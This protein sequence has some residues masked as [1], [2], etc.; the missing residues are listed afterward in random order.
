MILRIAENERLK[1][2]RLCKDREEIVFSG[3]SLII[4]KFEDGYS[5]RLPY[6]FK[7]V[8]YSN[9]RIGREIIVFQDEIEISMILIDEIAYNHF[10]KLQINH[11]ILSIGN[12]SINEIKIDCADSHSEHMTVLDFKTKK[13][14]WRKGA[15]VYLNGSKMKHE[16]VW[17]SGDRIDV[18]GTAICFSNSFFMINKCG[19]YNDTLQ[20]YH[21]CLNESKLPEIVSFKRTYGDIWFPINELIINAPEPE[22]IIES[23]QQPMIYTIGPALMMSLASLSAGMINA[24]RGY[25]AGRELIDTLSYLIIPATMFLSTILWTPLSR[26]IVRRNIR[27]R[28]IKRKN[29]Y[30]NLMISYKEQVRVF[31]N[32]YHKNSTLFYPDVRTLY[33]TVM[34]GESILQHNEEDGCLIRLGTSTSAINVRIKNNWKCSD[35]C[36]DEITAKYQDEFIDESGGAYFIDLFAYSTILIEKGIHMNSLLEYIMMQLNCY[37]SIPIVLC[38]DKQ[39]EFPEWMLQMPSANYSDGRYIVRNNAE[40]TEALN[41]IGTEKTVVFHFRDMTKNSEN[42]NTVD[43]FVGAEEMK[44]DLRITTNDPSSIM[45]MKTHRQDLLQFPDSGMI[46]MYSFF[47]RTSHSDHS[48]KNENS[49]F[50]EMNGI[51]KSSDLSI[52]SLRHDMDINKNLFVMI[53]MDETG[54]EIILDLNERG[55]GPHGIIAGMTGSG[56]SELILSM[57]L[58]VTLHYSPK[59]LQ[60]AVVDFKGGGIASAM[61]GLPHIAGVID[62]LDRENMNRALVSFKNECEYRERQIESMSIKKHIPIMNITEYRR[63][64][65]CD[66]DLPYI[67]DLIIVVDEFAELKR[68]NSDLLNDLISVARIGRSL[69]IHLI[70][71][72]QKPSGVINDQILSNCSY[73]ICLR[74]AERQDSIEMMHNDSAVNLQH[75]GEFVLSLSKGCIKGT[76]PYANEIQREEGHLFCLVNEKRKIIKSN[77]S[78][79][80]KG[81]PEIVEVI[82]EIKRYDGNDFTRRKLWLPALKEIT[83]KDAEKIQYPIG[84]CDDYYHHLQP[85]LNI[86]DTRGTIFVSTDHDAKCRM[87]RTL[88]CTLLICDARKDEIYIID[89]LCAGDNSSIVTSPLLTDWFGSDYEEKLEC[90]FNHIQSDKHKRIDVI[91]T[92][93]SRFYENRDRNKHILHDLLEHSDDY[94]IHIHIFAST[95]GILPYREYALINDRYVLHDENEQDV[96]QA[97]ETFQKI[98]QKEPEGGL[99]KRGRVL[100]CRWIS[101]TSD[102]FKN[103]AH[104]SSMKFGNDKRYILPCMPIKVYSSMFNGDGIPLGMISTDQWLSINENVS[105]LI[106]ASYNEELLS[107]QNIIQKATDCKCGATYRQML[108][109]IH[110]MTL[111]D[112]EKSERTLP[113]LYIGRDYHEQYVFR[114]LHKHLKEN[115]GM[116]IGKEKCMTVRLISG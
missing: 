25:T 79:L 103:A 70:L 20:P 107:F 99:V 53:G 57:I 89:D 67:G 35:K 72:T 62:N 42:A 100:R 59:D 93:L 18:L 94:D 54:S 98:I 61:D 73:K 38:A 51:K 6:G 46:D 4:F 69:G 76:A 106:V 2:V 96:G 68:D 7:S 86:C 64:W 88:L 58:Y 112:Y 31:K 45:I 10:D 15:P 111:G 97:L 109:N 5:I 108:E 71:S 56:K 116:Y 74:V 77:L 23:E 115:E 50:L 16:S 9:L 26:I 114:T 113:V 3:F 90:L 14:S 44:C 8:P 43:I 30:E 36:I 12:S 27:K 11:N 81:S 21:N 101:T 29:D 75:P 52:R 84:R 28:K 22:R 104:I 78:E 55:D 66:D 49:G 48:Y 105:I 95:A 92:D 80:K 37:F 24:Y 83:L 33:N 87:I 40:L 65:N 47:L 39:Y 60:I 34:S 85:W 63:S 110:F 1:T 102:D 19:S 82:R 32:S 13:I 17:K 41:K 91:I